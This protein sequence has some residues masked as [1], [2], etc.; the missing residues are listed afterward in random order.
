[1]RL[2]KVPLKKSQL[3]KSVTESTFTIMESVTANTLDK[4]NMNVTKYNYPGNCNSN[5]SDSFNLVYSI[6]FF[7]IYLV[8]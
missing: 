3:F 4:V 5:N 8:S 2:T 1:M 6:N 7:G